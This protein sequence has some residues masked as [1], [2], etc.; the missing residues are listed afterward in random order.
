MTFNVAV[1]VTHVPAG[2]A[3]GNS[4]ILVILKFLVATAL[5]GAT[6]E[7]DKNSAE[8]MSSSTMNRES[9]I[10]AVKCETHSNDVASLAY[11]TLDIETKTLLRARHWA[12][13]C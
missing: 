4:W 1:T 8:V 11:L 13:R 12:I 9:D 5:A 10:R 2:P 6:T 3:E 7:T